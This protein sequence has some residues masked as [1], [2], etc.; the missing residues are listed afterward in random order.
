M[1]N[2]VV[3]SMS[4]D[5]IQARLHNLNNDRA[6][7]ERAL[8]H[9]R[10]QTRKDLAQEIREMVLSQGHDLTDILDLAVGKKRA[11]G[12]IRQA[13]S[14]TCYVDPTNSNNRY[15]RGV[16]PGWMKEQMVARGLDPKE[17]TD[18]EAFK[19]QYLQRQEG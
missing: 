6:V 16:L 4:V 15:V 1:S 9:R 3:E 2:E 12:R 14:Y 19:K 5:E 7:L 17:K 11:S 8:E 13:R 10:R 18:R